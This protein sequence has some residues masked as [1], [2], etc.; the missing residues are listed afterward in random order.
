M[1]QRT[2]SASYQYLPTPD[3][4]GWGHALLCCLQFEELCDASGCLWDLT[5]YI[6]NHGPGCLEL[7]RLLLKQGADPNAVAGQR[8]KQYT[9]LHILSCWTGASCEL[10]QGKQY[11]RA[12][13]NLDSAWV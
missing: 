7:V 3:I 4:Y 9:L 13:W 8:P 1:I 5:A 11:R 6:H 12:C 2:Q 10:V